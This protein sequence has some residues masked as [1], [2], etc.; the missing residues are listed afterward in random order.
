MGLKRPFQSSRSAKPEK[1]SGVSIA[2]VP[3]RHVWSLE[4]A[5]DRRAGTEHLS[6]FG[7]CGRDEDKGPD[8]RA[9]FVLER[10]AL[11][12]VVEA[13]FPGRWP[14]MPGDAAPSQKGQLRPRGLARKTTFNR[15]RKGGLSALLHL[16]PLLSL[17]TVHFAIL[18]DWQIPDTLRSIR[19]CCDC[20]RTSH[21]EQT[22]DS[23]G[24]GEEGHR[25]GTC[26]PTP[27]SELS[28]L[29]GSE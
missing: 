14:C 20:S 21:W 24:G 28:L 16:S 4:W 6:E 13:K 3:Q 10:P 1:L 23:A 22:V 9:P 25:K 27:D 19:R 12:H 15:G 29:W 26:K 2:C 18:G 8:C 11:L 7:S 17:Y 5:L